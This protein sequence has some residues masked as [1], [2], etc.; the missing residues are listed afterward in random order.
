M[1]SQIQILQTGGGY[2]HNNTVVHMGRQQKVK[3][4]LVGL[5]MLLYIVC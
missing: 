4:W 3:G 1:Q 5:G 2:A